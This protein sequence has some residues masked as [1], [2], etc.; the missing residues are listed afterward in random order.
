MQIAYPEEFTPYMLDRTKFRLHGRKRH[1]LLL[2]ADTLDGCT[3]Q[4]DRSASKDVLSASSAA[5][6]ESLQLTVDNLSPFELI[7]ISNLSCFVSFR[8]RATPL[9]SFQSLTVGLCVCR[10]ALLL[11][12]SHRAGCMEQ[13]TA[14]FSLATKSHAL[15]ARSAFPAGPLKTPFGLPWYCYTVLSA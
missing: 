2:F 11:R 9:T 1:A 6:S 3:V 8:Y 10:V 5:K 4:R 13:T 7:L 14:E 15:M 12:S